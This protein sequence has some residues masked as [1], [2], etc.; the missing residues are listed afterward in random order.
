MAEFSYEFFNPL[1]MSRIGQLDLSNVAY[2]D[3]VKG[4]G[5]F[6]GTVT[7]TPKNRDRVRNCLDLDL[8]MVAVTKE[9]ENGISREFA[10]LVCNRTWNPAESTLTF[11]APHVKSWFYTL[12]WGPNITID[13]ATEA[14]T[15][16]DWQF[17]AINT[18]Q[19]A[20]ARSLIS[21][22]L[23]R[24]GPGALKIKMRT[25]MSGRKR[26]VNI[27]GMQFKMV[28]AV[29]DGM[30]NRDD[31]FE[32][33]IGWR[34]DSSGKPEL[35]LQQFYPER[36]TGA[37]ELFFEWDPEG[38]G[39]I[40]DIGTI[41]ET[42]S[43]KRTR[44]WTTGTGSPP[45]QVVMYDD[46][47]DMTNGMALYRSTVTNYGQVSSASTLASHARVEREALASP[48]NLI[49]LAVKPNTLA[50]S[51]DRARVVIR[52]L[53]LDYD[54]PAVRIVDKSTYPGDRKNGEAVALTIDTLDIDL[55]DTDA[56]G[57]AG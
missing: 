1:T 6:G 34:L 16:G 20:I 26:D 57:D 25:E 43:G 52:D 17:R 36:S 32:W 51:G 40:L 21:A 10:G 19:F 22:S 18:D 9:D 44:V 23:Q 5:E 30:A 28:G 37:T 45:D 46:D 31:G 49:N 41:E 13:P 54:L 4:F 55:P 42:T 48:L 38:G 7:V 12:D 3:P 33:Q 50:G 14:V 56:E 53:W 27:Q 15:I 11:K 24:I 47:P 2:N 39:N 29:I 8:S 35:F